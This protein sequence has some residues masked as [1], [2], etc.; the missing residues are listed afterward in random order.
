M[1]SKAEGGPIIECLTKNVAVKSGTAQIAGENGDGYLTGENDY[2]YSAVAMTPAEN[3]DFI[4]YVTDNSS[5][6]TD[7]SN[8][9]SERS[10]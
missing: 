9:F 5:E 1:Y 7:L 6:A 4:M 2:I 8:P 10:C 3:P